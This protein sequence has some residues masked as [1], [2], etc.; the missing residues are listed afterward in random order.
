M[1]AENNFGI[2]EN[3][4]R[5]K[6]DDF[7]YHH[8]C[9]NIFQTTCMF[10]VYK[11]T[12]HCTAGVIALED[13]D[14]NI[15]GLMVYSIIQEPGVKS[16]FSKRAI[17]TGGPLILDNN[18]V[19][20]NALLTNYKKI[21]KKTNT[22]YSEI[23]NLFDI[24]ALRPSLEKENFVYEDHLTIHM[25]LTQSVETL[26]KA[27]HRGRASNIK[28]AIKKNVTVRDVSTTEELNDVYRLIKDTYER[29]GLPSPSPEL[30]LNT[31]KFM[32]EK[33]RFI[34]AFLDEKMIGCRVYLIY[35][36]FL[37]DWYA[38]GD[39]EYSGY[40]PSDLLPWKG[41]L[42][43]KESG[44]KTYDFAGA[45]KPNKEYSVRDYKLKFGGSLLNL[46]RYQC[47]HN[48]VLFKV[49]VLG[50]KIYKYVR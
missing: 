26:E 36:D 24:Q 27:L 40:H 20:T 35:K 8:P 6:W 2:N 22:I 21:I 42:S 47:I 30:F 5:K 37:Y 31:A 39:R 32:Q 18:P 23:R 9:G 15:V 11:S 34:A 50:M 38:A 43:A 19:Y 7:V 45:G 3:P 49:G 12:P 28:R 14:K 10:D 48:P 1:T 17:I 13:S 16:R 29:I 41:M 46:G 44:V 33:V 25:D 4:D